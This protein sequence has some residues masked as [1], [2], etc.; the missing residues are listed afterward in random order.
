MSAEK[1]SPSDTEIDDK[2]L[3]IMLQKIDDAK[4]V[5]IPEGMTTA[6]DKIAHIIECLR[7]MNNIPADDVDE[8]ESPE[9]KFYE[10]MTAYRSEAEMCLVYDVDDVDDLFFE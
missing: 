5:H 9:R 4:H 2:C 6:S 10:N 1:R 7:L 8:Y 3:E